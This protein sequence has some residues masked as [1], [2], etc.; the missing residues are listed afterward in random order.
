MKTYCVTG[1]CGFLG[2]AVVKALAERGNFVKVL[3]D[4]SRGSERRLAG[5][6][7]VR[8][9][10]GDVRDQRLCNYIAHG[11]DCIIH[12]AAVNGT[13][14]FYERPRE[15]L[16]VGIR[17]TLN[18]V[19]AAENNRVPEF[20]FV[21][22]SEVYQDALIIPTP[23]RVT[24]VVPDL[25]NPRYSY[26]GSK[27]AGELLTRWSGIP[28]T[29]IVRPHNVYGPDMGEEHVIPEFARRILVLPTEGEHQFTVQSPFGVTRSFCHV[30][31]FVLGLL[32]VLDKGTHQNVYNIGMEEETM[33][34]SLADAIAR[35]L[36]RRI[37]QVYYSGSEPKGSCLRRC[38]DLFK[39][40][41][42]NWEP[43]MKLEE[44]LRDTLEWYRTNGVANG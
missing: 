23:E 33:I 13:R 37:F 17:G 16:D 18:M 21:S 11:M 10:R 7:N 32:T 6:P 26:G 30:S 31:D 4:C 14:N 38:P 29:L 39:L 15:V 2:S 20:L 40:R 43:K 5:T 34:G 9:Y 22:S 3:D 28:R 1:G 36:G 27:I 12:M 8:I 19:A 42:L 25:D 24:L 41:C 35:Q 44:G